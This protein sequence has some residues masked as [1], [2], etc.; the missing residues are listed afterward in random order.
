MWK[1]TLMSISPEQEIEILA[2]LQNLSHE[3]RSP[4]ASILGYAELILLSEEELSEEI[5][6]NTQAILNNGNRL[7]EIIDQIQD[8]GN[9]LSSNN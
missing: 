7:Q 6:A 1:G 3:L 4:L 9:L 2:F 5:Q 8:F